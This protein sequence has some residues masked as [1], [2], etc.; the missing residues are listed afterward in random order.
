MDNFF[1]DY[2]QQ[3]INEYKKNGYIIRDIEENESLQWIKDFFISKS[4]FI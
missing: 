3:V 4:N 2:E 1:E